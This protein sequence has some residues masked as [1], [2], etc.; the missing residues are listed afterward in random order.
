MFQTSIEV[1]LRGVA[2]AP[3]PSHEHGVV[4]KALALVGAVPPW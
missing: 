1:R 3:P 2:S 4:L